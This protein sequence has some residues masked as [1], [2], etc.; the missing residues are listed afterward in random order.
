MGS[1]HVAR[2]SFAAVAGLA[3]VSA[4]LTGASGAARAGAGAARAVLAGTISTVAGGVGGPGPARSVAVD[5][6]CLRA[7]GEWLYIGTLDEVRRV[8]VLTGALTTVAGN[9]AVGP[10]GDGGIATASAF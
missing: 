4:G 8:N 7:A 1:R 5:A 2:L 3:L 9:N 6:W 10:E